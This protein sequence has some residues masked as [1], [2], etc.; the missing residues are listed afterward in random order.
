[1]FAVLAACS[2]GLA[3]CQS[4]SSRVERAEGAKAPVNQVCPIMQDEGNTHDVSAE[5]MTVVHRG[6]TVGFCCDHCIE[7]WNSLSDADKDA[8][9]ASAIAKSK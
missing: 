1:M 3:A 2:L 9:L 8:K 7:E 4:S 5:A 6:K